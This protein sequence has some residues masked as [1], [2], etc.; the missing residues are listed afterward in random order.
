M[1]TSFLTEPLSK[2][3]IEALNAEVPQKQTL[4]CEH[5][6]AKYDLEYICIIP[7]HLKALYELR[8]GIYSYGTMLENELSEVAM[9]S[10]E[11][12]RRENDLYLLE[13]RVKA[14]SD[15]LFLELVHMYPE[16]FQDGGITYVSG[17]K[18]MRVKK[19]KRLLVRCST[20]T[21]HRRSRPRPH[22]WAIS[23]CGKKVC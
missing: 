20:D 7:D 5:E 21:V 14:V 17:W 10:E 6:L 23:F 8:M 18:V 11:H 1:Y 12:V 19:R 3:V 22:L 13:H 4:S 16:V 2:L 15:L 9:H